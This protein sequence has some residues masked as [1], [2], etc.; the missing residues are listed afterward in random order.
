MNPDSAAVKPASASSA[1]SEELVAALSALVTAEARQQFL[2]A[3]PALV[4][5]ETVLRLKDLVLR[6]LRSDPAQALTLAESCLAIAERL[7]HPESLAHG[8]RSKAN[9]LY[10]VGEHKLAVEYHRRAADVYISLGNHDELAR[11]LSASIQ[12]HLLLGQYDE[13]FAAAEE[14]R[15]IFQASGNLWRLARLE[16]NLGNIYHR[17]DRFTE[18]LACYQRAYQELL[19]QPDAEA[20]AA[21]LSNIATCQ[22]TLN[23]FA[24]A[25]SSYQQAREWCERHR[26]PVLVA[27]AD[28]NIA[29]LYYLRGEYGRAIQM[30]RNTREACR[31]NDDKYHFALCH[32]DLSE[33]YL[34]LNLS[35]EA[36]ETARQGA[37]LFEALGMGY[38]HAKCLANLAT[39][40]GQQGQAFRALELFAQARQIFVRE[41]NSVWPSLI[42]LYCALLLCEEG[43]LFEARRL[44]ASAFQFFDSSTLQG[45]AVLCCLL[46]S[47]L[48]ARGGE[49]KEA[50]SQCSSALRKLADFDSPMLSYQADFQMGELLITLH[51][52]KEAYASLQAAQQ[53]LE[54]LRGNMQAQELKIA[55]MKNR[56]AVYEQL[57][58]LCLS[59]DAGAGGREQAFHYVEQSKSRSL[60]DLMFQSSQ[61]QPRQQEGQSL[62]ARNIRELREEL[63]WY[64][65]RIEQ[66][67]LRQQDRSPERIRQLQQELRQHEDQFVRVLR[68]LPSSEA[69][70][71]CLKAPDPLAVDEVRAC[72]PEGGA[73]LE[74][75]QIG[76]ELYSAV[77][78][79]S[80]FEI[81]PVT[82]NSRVANLLRLLQFQMSKF[83]LGSEYV[84]RFADQLLRAT[85]AHLKELYDELILPVQ[86]YLHGDH[87]VVVPHGLLHY[88]PFHAFY[89]GA[90]YLDQRFTVSYAPSSSIFALCQQR[91]ANP[92]GPS[93]VFGVADARA[94]YIAEEAQAVA[95]ALPRAQLFL[96]DDATAENLRQLGGSARFV[97]IASHGFFRQDNPLFSGIRMADSHLSLHDLYQF[98]LPAELVT[99]SGCVTGLASV[100]AGDELM[101]LAR[102]LLQAG[103][104]SLLL[105]LWNVHDHSTTQLMTSFYRGLAAGAAKTA[106]LAI[107]MAELREVHPHPY[108]WASFKII[109]SA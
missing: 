102:G 91:P 62:L 6:Q 65:H 35:Q 43:R 5:P 3:H 18:A 77:L 107:A 75:F 80:V 71:A 11:T 20:I 69:E 86:P 33:I 82:L 9:A 70:A 97:H 103:A 63:N 37:A 10:G 34:D 4:S 17:Q 98:K 79:R 27:Q 30:L 101:G 89:D 72:L 12:P 57:I 76:D 1:T 66:E 15:R 44:C 28:Y 109:G 39:A 32:M 48:H 88:L 24:S 21:V 83:Q 46:M 29:W 92:G 59:G 56:L 52:R 106:A 8:F 73:V 78:S 64:Y 99:L 58:G 38:E 93:L 13:A 23:D 16:I 51:Q 108:Y 7:N 94:P 68:E 100:A 49:I 61:V 25:L 55:F 53:H 104:K 81:V 31:A 84:E 22:I 90:H 14:A 85:R 40:L 47:R 67:Q 74:Y 45:K 19:S 105:S 96:N 54:S 50:V 87:L 95:Q 42:D 36:E 41:K 2:S 60:I 26:M